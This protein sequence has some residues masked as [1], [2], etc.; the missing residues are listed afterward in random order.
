[1]IVIEVAGGRT[2]GLMTKENTVRGTESNNAVKHI[3]LCHVHDNKEEQRC[4]GAL[5]RC[6]AA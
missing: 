5:K 1:M 2:D 3:C 6:D 4:Q